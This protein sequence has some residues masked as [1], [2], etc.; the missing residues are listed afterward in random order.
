M[1]AV[2]ALIL[3]DFDRAAPKGMGHVKAGGN[4]AGMLRRSGQAKKKGLGITLHLDIAR[5]VEV[6]ESSSYGFLGVKY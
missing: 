2:K 5:H 6:V 4:C 1:R 3:H